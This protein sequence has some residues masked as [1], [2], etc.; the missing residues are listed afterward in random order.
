M[1]QLASA[2]GAV[3]ADLDVRVPASET[4]KTGHQPHG[5]ERRADA[6]GQHSALAAV[7][8]HLLDPLSQLVEALADR[9]QGRLAG[10]G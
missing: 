7:G 1:R 9:R 2:V 8:A 4:L 5:G 3:D 6:D 10:I